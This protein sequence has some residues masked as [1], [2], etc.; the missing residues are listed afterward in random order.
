MFCK[1]PKQFIKTPWIETTIF[2]DEVGD[3]FEENVFEGNIVSQIKDSLNYIKTKVIAQRVQK[4]EGQAEARRYFNYPYQAI[5]EALVN[6]VYHKSY[7]EDV[8]IEIRVELDRI[9]II[10][11]PGPLPP[12]NK[13]NLNAK[14]VISK[15]YRNRRIGEFLKEYDLTEQKNTGFRKIRL[16]LEKNGSPKPEFITDENRVQFVTRIKIH[17]EFKETELSDQ[18]TP[19]ATPQDTPQAMKI[20]SILKFCIDGKTREEIQDKIQISD[21][22]YFRTDLLNP[23]IK[24][25]LIELTI[26]DKPNSPNQKYRTTT[27]G[28]DKLKGN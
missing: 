20:N 3:K 10:S 22:K 28:L 18:A 24:D 9:D 23:L 17:P 11:Y 19:Q 15:K 25:G 5:E 4:I 12:L 13:D 7:E 2:F 1:N 21:R 16:A 14:V 8:P 27:K 26:P 6:A